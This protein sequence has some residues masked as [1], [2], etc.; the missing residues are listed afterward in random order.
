MRDVQILNIPH[1]IDCRWTLTPLL[2]V[3]TSLPSPETLTMKTHPR[4]PIF[5]LLLLPLLAAACDNAGSPRAATSAPTQ[6]LSL[7]EPTSAEGPSSPTPTLIRIPSMPDCSFLPIDACVQAT[8]A[9]AQRLVDA[10]PD[11]QK[12]TQ[13]LTYLAQRTADFRARVDTEIATGQTGNNDQAQLIFLDLSQLSFDTAR[14]SYLLAIASQVKWWGFSERPPE[15]RQEAARLVTEFSAQ[16]ALYHSTGEFRLNPMRRTE[17]YLSGEYWYDVDIQNE[18]IVAI[19]A[20]QNSALCGLDFD[21]Q[22]M[23]A[24]AQDYAARLAP[25]I[26]LNT[27]T[28]KEEVGCLYFAWVDE[29]LLLPLWHTGAIYVSFNT[30]GELQEFRN[31]LYIDKP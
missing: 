5:L 22:A 7:G 27:L 19:A 28:L 21:R 9:E 4:V 2:F 30:D 6:A 3:K 10:I 17:R 29:Y 31:S 16:E 11:Q 24:E 1:F 18:R 14:E 26:D 23:L 15:A 8:I 20:S 12:R 13:L 25:D